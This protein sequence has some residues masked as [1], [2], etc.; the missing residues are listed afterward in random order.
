MIHRGPA[1][2]RGTTSG[3]RRRDAAAGSVLAN[4]ATAGSPL[5]PPCRG[6]R[7]GRAREAACGALPLHVPHR[8]PPEAE[9]TIPLAAVPPVC[10]WRRSRSPS[11][12]RC[13]YRSSTWV[14]TV[15]ARAVGIVAGLVLGRGSAQRHR[16][17]RSW[18]SCSSA[19]GPSRSRSATGASRSPRS[20]LL[21]A[22]ALA[23]AGR[24]RER[25]AAATGATPLIVLTPVFF[26]GSLMSRAV[27]VWTSDDAEEL[28]RERARA[29][30][31]ALGDRRGS[32]SRSR[33][34]TA[35]VLG[36][37][38]GAL[39][40][41]GSFL[42]PVGNILVS[43]A[44]LRL[45]PALPADL[46]AGRPPRHRPRRRPARARSRGGERLPR[47]RA[48]RGPGGPSVDRRPGP[49]A[50]AL[51]GGGL[52]RHPV[53]APAHA[54]GARVRP[55]AARRH[56]RPSRAERSTSRPSC[57]PAS[58]VESRRPTGCGAGTA[59]CSP[60]SPAGGWT[61]TRR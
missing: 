60:C 47:P 11:P 53:D 58:C 27:S 7:S 54:R 37:R 5:A 20:F 34:S 6:R 8:R 3:G 59:R 55:D 36:V 30:A 43:A 28:M 22:L 24:R 57:P 51:R 12:S 56:P 13:R 14:G 21:G 44:R 61:R 32:G 18:S 17:H 40:H 15:A 31:A 25:G 41:V 9:P 16:L 23:V 2:A 35:V 1:P 10:S 42:A 52:G 29:L 46:L 38:D 49:G 33:W 19:S 4:R 50:R 26:V 45:R 39:D 48:S